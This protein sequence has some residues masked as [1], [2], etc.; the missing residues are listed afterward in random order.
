M[1]PLE[2]GEYTGIS[3][4]LADPN[5]STTY[6][7]RAIIRNARTDATI[8]TVDLDSK[9]LGRYQAEWHVTSTVPAGGFFISIT[10]YVYTDSGYTTLSTDYSAESNTYLIEPRAKHFGGG[11][12]ASVN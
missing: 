2:P 11:G 1:P 4:Q 12:G 6:Y 9:G 7:V 5:D 8:D 10:T 3:R